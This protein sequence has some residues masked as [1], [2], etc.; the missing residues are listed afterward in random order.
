M[1]TVKK[2]RWRE[3]QLVCCDGCGAKLSGHEGIQI[4]VGSPPKRFNYCRQACRM[5]DDEHTPGERNEW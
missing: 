5:I 2:K 4:R 3:D 1:V